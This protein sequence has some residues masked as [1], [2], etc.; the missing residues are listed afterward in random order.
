MRLRA[1][2]FLLF[3]RRAAHCCPF[4]AAASINVCVFWC[5]WWRRLV[6]RVALDMI[7]LT[8]I[9]VVGVFSDST[10]GTMRFTRSRQSGRLGHHKIDRADSLI[11]TTMKSV[12]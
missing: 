10:R 5:F 8:S 7:E 2:C 3:D 4:I 11:R 12:V 9:T 1:L 6:A